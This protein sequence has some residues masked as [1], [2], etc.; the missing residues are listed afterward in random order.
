MAHYFGV[1][2]TVELGTFIS[3]CDLVESEL[4]FDD[5]DALLVEDAWM[6]LRGASAPN[7]YVGYAPVTNAE[8]ALFKEDF[9]YGAGKENYPVVNIMIYDAK[10]YCD[11][12]TART[13]STSATCQ[14]KK[15]GFSVP[16]TCPRMSS[17]TPATWNPD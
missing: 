13:E 8:Y 6:V 11:W 14:A 2:Q 3:S 4:E 7:A 12:L 15:C 10:A 9:T 17:G 5:P 1:H 16:D